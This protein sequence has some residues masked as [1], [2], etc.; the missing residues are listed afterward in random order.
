MFRSRAR[1]LVG[2]ALAVLVVT[3]PG[4][5]PVA[6]AVQS[7]GIPSNS[8]S[9]D[10]DEA[11]KEKA[12][13]STQPAGPSSPLGDVEEALSPL[14]KAVQSFGIANDPGFSGV[15]MSGESNSLTIYRF[16]DDLKEYATRYRALVPVEVGLDYLPAVMSFSTHANIMAGLPGRSLI[17]AGVKMTSA[18]RD[19]LGGPIVVGYDPKSATPTDA[20]RE[21]ILGA[22]AENLT[23]RPGVT[24]AMSGRLDDTNPYWGAPELSCPL[25][26]AACQEIFVRPDLA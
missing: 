26:Q 15:K 7:A 23:F 24:I 20:V 14:Y 19:D 10:D 17:E 21:K 1:S 9:S 11:A 2:T 22:T 16:S 18:G 25:K 5:G 3:L 6:F 13:P 4:Q 12:M 8:V